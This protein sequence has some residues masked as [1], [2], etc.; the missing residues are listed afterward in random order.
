MNSILVDR[1]EYKPACFEI[2]HE[3]RRDT[4]TRVG[5]RDHP[6]G[7]QKDNKARFPAPIQF[8]AGSSSS[9]LMDLVED[10]P[11]PLERLDHFHLR[12]ACP[13]Q[14]RQE[15]RGGTLV[16]G[17]PDQPRRIPIPVVFSNGRNRRGRQQGNIPNLQPRHPHKVADRTVSTTAQ[18]DLYNNQY[19]P[20][21]PR[22]RRHLAESGITRTV[23]GRHCYVTTKIRDIFSRTTPGT[24]TLDAIFA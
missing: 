16:Q 4:L 19:S 20:H 6:R 5:P 13:G 2:N 12:S 1:K 7:G 22:G 9:K 18:T 8:E 24:N 23:L 3:Q 17:A 15:Q 21:H 11:Q 10:N 14:S